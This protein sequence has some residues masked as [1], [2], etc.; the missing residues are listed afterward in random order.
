MNELLLEGAE[1]RKERY[2]VSLIPF[3]DINKAST[4][5]PIKYSHCWVNR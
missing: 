3:I 2:R 4:M 5:N 1:L